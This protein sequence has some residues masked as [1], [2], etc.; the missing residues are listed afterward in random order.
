M[1]KCPQCNI[2]HKKRGKY[3]GM[4]CYE[5]SR[6]VPEI[7]G[8]RPGKYKLKYCPNCNRPHKREGPFCS[9]GCHNSYR[10]VSQKQRDNM[11]KVSYEYKET[12][13]G[14]ANSKLPNNGLIA[15]DYA[16][17]IPD[18]SDISDYSDVLEGFDKAEKW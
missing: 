5:K 17:A 4:E 14:I 12:P 13:E 10:E 18:I 1:K 9:Q 6:E 7:L 11:R 16:I 15:D 8:M 2:E 3:C